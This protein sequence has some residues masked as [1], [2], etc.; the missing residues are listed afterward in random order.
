MSLAPERFTT[1]PPLEP[2]AASRP[3]RSP[4]YGGR[5]GF[6]FFHGLIRLFGVKPAYAWLACFVTPYYVLVRASA[7]RTASYY[8]K[9]RFPGDGPLR[10]LWRTAVHFYKFGQ[11]LIDQGVMGILGRERF[12]VDFPRQRELYD[13]ARSGRGLVLLTSHI[14]SWQAAMA[15][16]D[17]LD[18]PVSFQFQLEE[19][20]AGRH[21]FDL[22]GQRGQFRFVSPAGFLGG[23]VE[24]TQALRQGECIAVMGDRAFGARTRPARFLGA[25]AWFPA[26]PY[27][28]ALRTGAGIAALLTVRTGERSYR[29]EFFNLRQPPLDPALDHDAAMA[30]LQRRYVAALEGWLDK[31]PYMWFNFFD[32][33]D[34]VLEKNSKAEVAAS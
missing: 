4:D 21:F 34:H 27:H 33:W 28:L 22:A 17:A 30:E 23:V 24:L 16:M 3:Y 26:I 5:F 7:R 10:R 8:L 32:I 11:V 12:H 15:N 6:A 14:G 13:L 19:H 1:T 25:E 20:T 9:H 18:V 29:I 31:Y 2:G